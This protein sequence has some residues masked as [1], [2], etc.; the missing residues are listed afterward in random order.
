MLPLVWGNISGADEL[1]ATGTAT[2][3]M[4]ERT[5]I[6]GRLLSF[7]CGWPVLCS[8]PIHDRCACACV[9]AGEVVTGVN[10]TGCDALAR[11]V[12]DWGVCANA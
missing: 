1:T 10:A 5:G 12:V 8:E 9:A 2:T 4:E 6:S 11:G 7:R 3:A